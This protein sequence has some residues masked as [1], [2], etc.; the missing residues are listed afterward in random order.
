MPQSPE[1]DAILIAA[2]ERR[3]SLMEATNQLE[4]IGIEPVKA[5]DL[6][7]AWFELIET[8]IQ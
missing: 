8:P 5:R 6:L 7:V 2:A 1:E 4:D 3:I